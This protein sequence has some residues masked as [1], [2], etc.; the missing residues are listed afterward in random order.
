MQQRRFDCVFHQRRCT[1][2]GNDGQR[3]IKLHSA[4]LSFPSFPFDHCTKRIQCVSHKR[5][6]DVS[7]HREFPFLKTFEQDYHYG[8]FLSLPI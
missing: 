2:D 3:C 1:D 4:I 8:M 5:D 7:R 6:N